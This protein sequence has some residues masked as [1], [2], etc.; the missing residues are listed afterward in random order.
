MTSQT[1]LQA[2]ALAGTVA[3]VAYFRKPGMKYL[4]KKFQK[5]LKTRKNKNKESVSHN[6]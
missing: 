1:A 5:K 3:T 6:P 2:G 4:R